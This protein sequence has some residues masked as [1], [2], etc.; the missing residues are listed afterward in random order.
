MVCG[1]A[2]SATNEEAPLSGPFIQA[3]PGRGTRVALTA[4]GWLLLLAGMVVALAR[5]GDPPAATIAYA[6]VWLASTTVPGVLVWRALARPSTAVQEVAFGSV[7]GVGLLL[8][9]WVPATLVHR[10]QLMWLWPVG[11]AVSFLAA[12]RLRRHW[13]PARPAARRTP[14]R[15][16][17]AMIAVCG[18]AFARVYGS[19]LLHEPLAPH[20]S[21]I[22]QDVWYELALTQRLRHAVSIHDPAAAGV[23][24]DYHWFSNAHAA[25]TSTLSGVPAYAVV[26]HLWIVAML[27]TFV[28]AAAAATERL[29]EASPDGPPAVRRWWAGPLAALLVAAVPVDLFLGGRRVPAIDN[30]FVV[31]STSGI[32]ALTV[33]LCLVGPVLDLLHGVRSPGT[34][35]LVGALLALSGGT[36]PSILPVVAAASA[37][38]LVVQWV[39]TRRVP[40]VPLVL[41]LLPLCLIPVAALVVMGSTS[42]SRL[43]LFETL[44]LDPAFQQAAG[45]AVGLPGHGGWLAPGLSA[46]PGRMWPVATGLLALFVLTELPRLLGLLGLADRRLR[47]DPGT[48]WCAGVVAS[49]FGGLWVL[50]HPGYSQHY[51]WR[52][53]IGLGVAMTIANVV[54]LVPPTVRA[55]QLVVPLAVVGAVGLA[56]GSGLALAG[57]SA[58]VAVAGRLVPYG[59]AAA[60]LVVML[61]LLR[62]RAVSSWRKVRLS[63]LAVVTCFCFAAGL[64]VSI[65][66]AAGDSRD[67]LATSASPTG[68]P[69]QFVSADEQRAA[70]WLQRHSRPDD[71]VATNVFCS[72]PQYAARCHHV[73][74]WVAALTG[75]QLLVGAWAYTK[76]S[77]TAYAHVEVPYQEAGSPWPDRVALSLAAVRSPSPAVL[78]RLRSYGVSWIFADRRAT[79]VSP[80]L[81]RYARLVYANGDVLVYQVPSGR[82]SPQVMAG[83]R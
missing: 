82:D 28:L 74:F 11:A 17:V 4:V 61:L 58:G 51:F 46:S 62:R 81:R 42:G 14:L 55:R 48:W 44:S 68:P 64:P 57:R 23:P 29:L 72:P 83:G 6:A 33:I 8:L 34:W 41:T 54:R 69:S 13:L 31:S 66:L 59:V 78:A 2:P 37:L 71:V 52:I 27:V 53:V 3:A 43:Q 38:V 9:A 26:L 1:S 77:L 32:L 21:T 75:R 19:R 65:G 18:I 67:V 50:A 80:R 49:G 12:P 76:A 63:T 79:P 73:S 60:V 70:L 45:K 39:R 5:I 15:W 25:A 10:P 35:A 40:W 30:G 24:L 47:E 16:H 20:P 56:T 36:K 7:L 22:F